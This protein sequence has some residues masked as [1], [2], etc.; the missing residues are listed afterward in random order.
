MK[1]QYLQISNILTFRYWERI[2]DAQKIVL[3]DGLNIVIGQ[4]GAGKSTALEILN[5]LFKKILFRHYILDLDNYESRSQ[6]S[7]EHARLV[8]QLGD[9]NGD[10]VIGYRLDANWS[11][12]TADRKILIEI[13]LDDVDCRNIQFLRE[14]SEKLKTVADKYSNQGF[15]EVGEPGL[16]LHIEVTIS[17]NGTFI[18]KE[19]TNNSAFNYFVRFNYYS[20]LL[21][22][23]NIENKTDILREL[24]S[25]FVMISGYRNYQNFSSV[26]SLATPSKKYLEGLKQVEFS[27]SFNGIEQNEPSVFS[28]VRIRC[29]DIHFKSVLTSI[30]SEAALRAANSAGFISAINNR[31]ERIGL[32]VRLEF[33][34]QSK[35]EYAFSFYTMDNGAPIRDINSLSAG[36]KAIIHL[37]FETYGRADLNSGL[38]I[39]DEPEL[40]LHY[41]FQHLYLAVLS[42]IMREQNCQYI[43]VTHSDAFINSNTID[44]V[45]RFSLDMNNNCVV[46]SP[47][48]TASEK[49]LIRILDNTK[50]TYAFFGKKVV[51]VEGDTDRY[52]FKAVFQALHPTRSRD[53]SILDIGGK[54]NFLGWRDFFQSFGVEVFYIGDFDNIF[55]LQ[56]SGS[57]NIIPITRDSTLNVVKERKLSEHFSSNGR[58]WKERIQAVADR[59]DSDPKGSYLESIELLSRYGRLFKIT[60]SEVNHEVKSMV[61]DLGDIM[62][63]LRGD[64]IFILGLGSLEEYTG[65][66][67]KDIREVVRLCQDIEGWLQQDLDTVHE[68]KNIVTEICR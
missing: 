27:K 49:T 57:E 25:P 6:R 66:R 47:D 58:E 19:G 26:I 11:T 41:Q 52:F 35:W 2:E 9:H 45:T 3:N 40:H 38:V 28:L 15:E 30:D 53:I 8:L 43:I 32:K 62:A 46:H 54:G 23:H 22:L 61:Q 68:I 64:Q 63:A 39:I 59:A 17:N 10:N 24:E 13:E 50:S 16:K 21:Y 20:A 55:T 14:N 56:R 48:I 7:I 67:T 5:F 65:T 42:D 36:Q 34:N 31:L 60:S 18:V 1:I 44:S 4:N 37:V 51:L 12:E 33:V 29:A